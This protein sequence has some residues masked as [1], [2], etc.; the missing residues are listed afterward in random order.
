MARFNS[1]KMA[2]AAEIGGITAFE[3]KYNALI[4][5]LDTGYIVETSI[6]E[7]T[8][9]VSVDPKNGFIIYKNGDMIAGIA[10]VGGEYGLISQFLT[11]SPDADFYARVGDVTVGAQDY[12]G[13]LGFLKSYSE[14]DPV[15]YITAAYDSPTNHLESQINLVGT[16]IESDVYTSSEEFTVHP[17]SN[18][19]PNIHAYYDSI[20]DE[21]SLMANISNWIKISAGDSAMANIKAPQIYFQDTTGLVL[22]VR[23]SAFKYLGY[24]VW[25]DGNDG[26]LFKAGLVSSIDGLAESGSYGVNTVYTGFVTHINWDTNFAIQDV[27]NVSNDFKQ[28]RTKWGGTWGSWRKIWDDNNFTPEDYVQYVPDQTFVYDITVVFSSVAHSDGRYYSSM[29]PLPYA[30]EY[31]ISNLNCYR[32]DG[33]GAATANVAVGVKTNLGFFVTNDNSDVA[34]KACYIQFTLAR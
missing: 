22:D 32:L 30:N 33:T 11:S 34:D 29:I 6:N 1:A 26:G 28:Y 21:I 2:L 19:Y 8:I 20:N 31:T 12:T 5:L 10:E 18:F 17:V 15:L 7:D 27:Y 24:D 23:R 16:V 14:I 13:F 4:D 3:R 25:H 9:R